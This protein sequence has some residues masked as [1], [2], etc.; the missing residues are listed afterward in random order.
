MFAIFFVCVPLK[1]LLWWMSVSLR[2]YPCII[3]ILSSLL[4][5]QILLIDME[6]IYL[7][8]TRL[9]I[10]LIN[11]MCVLYNSPPIKEYRLNY[12]FPCST[13]KFELHNLTSEKIALSI[14]LLWL[15]LTLSQSF[16]SD[17][18]SI[19]ISPVA[20]ARMST[21]GLYRFHFVCGRGSSFLS[22]NLQ[23]NENILWCILQIP[24]VKCK[25]IDHEEQGDTSQALELYH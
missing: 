7:Y 25:N 17:L 14:S 10:A 15:I 23:I 5:T 16:V 19:N 20:A 3:R 9:P 8:N 13:L 12:S 18:A 21:T 4:N 6:Q 24:Y 1:L 11:Y 2:K 22:K